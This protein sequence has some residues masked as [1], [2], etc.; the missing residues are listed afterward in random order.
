MLWLHVRFSDGLDVVEIENGDEDEGG[1][2]GV[3]AAVVKDKSAVHFCGYGADDRAHKAGED[4]VAEAVLAGDRAKAGRKREAVDVRL[5]GEG[6][7][8]VKSGDLA[9]DNHKR[10]ER[11]I[12]H[13]DRENVADVLAV[14]GEGKSGKNDS[15]GRAGEAHAGGQAGENRRNYKDKVQVCEHRKAVYGDV[16]HTNL[17]SEFIGEVGAVAGALKQLAVATQASLVEDESDNKRKREKDDE[18]HVHKATIAVRKRIV[19]V[20]YYRSASRLFNAEGAIHKGVEEYTED[21]DSKSG[22]VKAVSVVH[23]CRSGQERGDN[24]ADGEPAHERKHHADPVDVK[25]RGVVIPYRVSEAKLTYK[26][27]KRG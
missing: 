19:C 14:G 1:E 3:E 21:A 8:N 2:A 27:G 18:E 16:D 23:R 22:L 12:A 20:V 11:N 25:G 26:G 7:R 10:E 9:D 6:P 24:E 13:R 5:V 4:A 15:D 17:H